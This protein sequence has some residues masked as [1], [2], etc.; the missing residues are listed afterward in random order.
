MKS[1]QSFLRLLD[2]LDIRLWVEGDLL[3]CNAPKGV[4]TA[5]LRTELT[6]RKAEILSFLKAINPAVSPTLT[7]IQP[8]SRDQPLPL[9]FAQQRL[10]FLAQLEGPSSTYNEFQALSIQGIL[11]LDV[12]EQSLTE[13]VRRHEILRTTLPVVDGSPIQVIEPPKNIKP[14]VIDLQS[15]SKTQQATEVHRQMIEEAERPFDLATGP[16]FRVTVLRLREAEHVLLLAMP[17]IAADRWS[18]SIFIREVAALYMALLRQEPS[19]LTGLAIQYADFAHWQRQWLQGEVLETQ[20]NYWKQQLAGAPQLL[21]LPTDR[22]RPPVQRFRGAVER[23]DLDADLTTQLRQ[24]G[25]QAGTTLFMTLLAAFVVLLYRYTGQ[26]DIV[27][28]SPIANRNR[29]EIEP[30]IGFFVN[31]LV[32]RTRLSDNPAFADFLSQVR[33]VALDAYAH[34]DLPFEKLVEE[35]QPQRS[36]SYS[37][38]FQV[39]F[40]LQNEPKEALE[41]PGLSLTPIE[42]DESVAEKFDL[43][44]FIS[45][46]ASGLTGMWRYNI[47]LFDAATIE[48]MSAHFQTLLAAIVTDPQ[49][50]VG[51]LPL[52]QTAERY[53]VL[54]SWN[55]TQTE[56]PPVISLS[57]LFEVQ[58]ERT[59]HAAAVVFEDQRLSYEQLNHRANQLARH[60][61]SL[62][63]GPESRVGLYVER[64]LEMLVGLWGV[65]KAGGAYVPLDPTHPRQRVRFLIEDAQ[66]SVLLTQQG[67]AER[68]SDSGVAVI[69]LDADWPLVAQQRRDNPQSALR[70]DNLAYVIYTSGSTGQP[71]GAAIEH[72]SIVNYVQGILQ[73]L[74][75][76]A[77]QQWAMVSTLAADLG[78]TVLFPALCTGGCLHVLSQERVTD[79]DAFADYC[80]QRPIDILKI[81]PSHL[82]ALQSGPRPGRA[83]PRRQL[84]LGGEAASCEWVA[85]LQALAPECKILNHYGPTEAT[86]GVLTYPVQGRLPARG[87]TPLGRPLANTEVYILDR[88]L[89]PVPV[90]VPGELHIGGAGLARGYL[91]QPALTAERFIPHPFSDQPEARLYKTGDMARYRADGAIEFLGRIDHQVKIRGF[92]IELGE[93]EAVLAQHPQVQQGVVITADDGAGD[94]RL[95]AYAA[96]AGASATPSELRRFLRERLPEYMTP[97]TFVLLDALPMTSNGKADRQALPAPNIDEKGLEVEESAPCNPTEE[98]LAVIWTDLLGVAV[99]KYDNFFDLGGHSLLATRA[100]TRIRETFT[101]DLPLN[102]VFEFPTVAELGGYI[103]DTRRAVSGGQ[104]FSVQPAPRDGELA[105][106]FAQERLW[107]LDQ[108]EEN[109][110]AY[111]VPAAIQLQGN[112]QVVAL[113]QAVSEIVRRHESLRTTFPTV[114]GNPVQ[115]I[116]SEWSM[117]IPIQDLKALSEQA[118]SSQVRQLVKGEAERPFDLSCGPLLR[119]TLLR[120]APD[121]HVLLINLH[122]IISDGWSRRFV[123]LRELTTLYEAFIQNQPSPL[124]ELPIQYVDFAH[125]Q[126]QWLTGQVLEKQLRYWRQE[127][128][129]SLPVLDLPTDRPRPPIQTFRGGHKSF[130]LNA[131]L[132]QKLKAL[133]Q[134]SGATL[135]MTLLAAFGVLL[136]RYSNQ[137]DIAVGSPIANRFHSELEPLIGLFLNTLVLRINLEGMPSFLELLTR[138]RQKALGAYAHQDLP[139]EK[140][141]EELKPSRQLSHSPWFQVMFIMQNLPSEKLELPGLTL[142]LLGQESWSNSTAKFDLTLVM[143]EKDQAL[144]GIF[145]YNSDLFDAA[146]IHRMAEHFQNLLTGIV[147]NPQQSISALPMLTPDEHHHLLGG[148]GH[149]SIKDSFPCG[150]V[151]Q[152][153]SA[154]DQSLFQGDEEVDR[155]LA[156]LDELSEEEAQQL[157]GETSQT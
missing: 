33:R 133:S 65:L 134:Q 45:E 129:G 85:A 6:E 76:A 5:A 108:L 13:I 153:T 53:Q 130:V 92:R 99:G 144:T 31:T 145:E 57:Q 30:L 138:V 44:L 28:G 83:M 115:V 113:E 105:L 54:R 117:K 79:P 152:R 24:L 126:R 41:L 110:A 16:L 111:N 14:L 35:L 23:F 155:L 148:W 146:T 109:S 22:P 121:S 62:G 11:R 107:F 2:K 95:V 37:P 141:M 147:A 26:E 56:F 87:V 93:I 69:C 10:W 58:V 156:E 104:C 88:Y 139:F 74:S 1:T 8:I 91:N 36:L 63:V 151:E 119:V 34:Q 61:Q 98:L 84:I 21:E 157:L 131:D 94:Q 64:S 48:R 7:P 4:L 66:V 142:T 51:Q 96:T 100:I 19:P 120:L 123:F 46:S 77:G 116:A 135:F 112:L 81:T 39:M 97:S 72:R 106:S 18:V 101:L 82:A 154:V 114:N 60:L 71:K 127:L 3:R 90:G 103:D 89:Q 52:L 125:W 27:V 124:P 43:T 132:T 143:E 150:H 68:L 59:P 149:P 9:S 73:R 42:N 137:K 75:A 55:E 15:L 49:Q 128:T 29:P 78:N 140:L 47:D 118:Q 12:L 20:L 122:H 40:V 80:E 86:V 38:L 32:L 136:S 70:P 102:K 25:Q 67:L 50:R 17:H